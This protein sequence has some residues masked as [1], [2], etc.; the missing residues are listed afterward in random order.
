M[1]FRQYVHVIRQAPGPNRM[2]RTCVDTQNTSHHVTYATHA[3]KHCRCRCE[4]IGIDYNFV[5]AGGIYYMQQTDKEQKRKNKSEIRDGRTMKLALGQGE[6]YHIR[7]FLIDSYLCERINQR[8]M[9]TLT[10]TALLFIHLQSRVSCAHH[11]GTELYYQMG[12]SVIYD[13]DLDFLLCQHVALGCVC[14]SRRRKLC[15]IKR[16]KLFLCFFH[17][18]S[19]VPALCSNYINISVLNRHLLSY[20]DTTYSYT[21]HSAIKYIYILYHQSLPIIIS[22]VRQFVIIVWAAFI[23]FDLIPF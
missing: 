10:P 22:C 17:F 14:C 13:D 15:S 8:I 1:G 5:T 21:Q 23:C 18:F 11:T 4:V 7:C 20:T 2:S 9:H 19:I 16:V 6:A 3:Q 12:S